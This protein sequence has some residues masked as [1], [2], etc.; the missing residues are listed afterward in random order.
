[1]TQRDKMR[2]LV[3]LFGNNADRI[4][5]EY[6]DAERRGEVQRFRNIRNMSAVEYAKWLLKD[7]KNKNWL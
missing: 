3:K 5:K 7:G 2:A 1:M 4:Y 6:A